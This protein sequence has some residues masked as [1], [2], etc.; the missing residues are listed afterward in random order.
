MVERH[1]AKVDVAGSSP[2]SRSFFYPC[3]VLTGTPVPVYLTSKS[4][5]FYPVVH[6]LTLVLTILFSIGKG[7]V[8]NPISVYI[9]GDICSFRRKSKRKKTQRSAYR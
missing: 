2:V 6:Y 8:N 5:Y 3:S 1:L 4:V 9:K 7:L